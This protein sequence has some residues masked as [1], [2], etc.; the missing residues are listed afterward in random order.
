[1]Q[2]SVDILKGYAADG[3]IGSILKEKLDLEE[4]DPMG[5]IWKTGFFI[6]KLFYS[7]TAL[8]TKIMGPIKELVGGVTEKLGDFKEGAANL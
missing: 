7:A 1:M 5:G 2:S 3:D 4:N 6:S 8:I